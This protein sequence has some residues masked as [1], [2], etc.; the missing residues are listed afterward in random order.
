MRRLAL[1][2]AAIAV[3]PAVSSC[4]KPA[5]PAPPTVIKLETFTS[6]DGGFSVDMPTP[7]QDKNIDVGKVYYFNCP[8][9]TYKVVVNTAMLAN[10]NNTS[11]SARTM[12]DNKTIASLKNRAGMYVDALNPSFKREFQLNYRYQGF[13]EKGTTGSI[14][15]NNDGLNHMKTKYTDNEIAL[16]NTVLN[17]SY[18]IQGFVGENAVYVLSVEGKADYVNSE[19]ATKFFESFKIN[20]DATISTTPIRH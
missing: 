1:L 11:K 8:D 20:G 9:V 6:S 18:I 16:P 10:T 17:G 5:P 4:A 2:V 12:R 19:E 15:G 13:E 14:A 3:L 7:H